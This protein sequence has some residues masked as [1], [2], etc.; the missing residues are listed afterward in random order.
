[1]LTE[2]A[3][4][5]KLEQVVV[6]CGVMWRM[7]L[8]VGHSQSCIQ[9]AFRGCIVIHGVDDDS[10]HRINCATSDRRPGCCRVGIVGAFIIVF[11]NSFF[12]CGSNDFIVI[13]CF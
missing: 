8:G 4:L 3:R 7:A 13:Y 1:M 12:G 9:D 6:H 5:H 10:R 2:D 11:Y